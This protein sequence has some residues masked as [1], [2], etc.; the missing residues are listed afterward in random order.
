[1]H[2]R[3]MLFSALLASLLVACDYTIELSGQY[4]LMRLSGGD[5]FALYWPL[6]YGEGL[7]VGPTVA[8]YHDSKT[9]IVGFVTPPPGEPEG[10]R[11]GYFLV[12]KE[13]RRAYWGL[14]KDEWLSK[15]HAYGVE[16]EPHLSRPNR[17]HAWF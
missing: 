14:T 9:L 13:A 4:R 10:Y 15:L 16:Q 17:L 11:E 8:R 2:V 5:Y 1:M 3:L 7:I 6:D 12:D